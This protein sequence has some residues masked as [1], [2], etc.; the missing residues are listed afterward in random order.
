MNGH[1]PVPTGPSDKAAGPYAEVIVDVPVHAVDRVFHYSVPD[2]L[3]SRVTVGSRVLVPFGG[4]RVE[5]YVVGFAASTTVARVRPLLAVQGDGAYFDADGLRLA[6]WLADRYLALEADALRCLAPPGATARRQGGRTVGPRLLKGY[7]LNVPPEQGRELVQRLAESG[8]RRQAAAVTE[9]LRFADG[10]EPLPAS[11]LSRQTGVSSGSLQSLAKQGILVEQTVRIERRPLGAVSLPTGSKPELTEEQ[12]AALDVLRREWAREQPRPVLLHGVTGSGK[13]E[14]YLRLIEDVLAA[15]K[16]AIVLVPEIALTPQTFSRFAARFGD[17]VALLHSRLSAGERF[18]QWEKVATGAAPVVIGARSAIFAPVQ[19]LGLVIVDEEHETSYK[20]E[21]SPRYH[22]RD[23]AVERARQVGALCVLG[24]ATPA[25][26]SWVKARQGD[27]VLVGMTKRVDDRPMPEVEVVDM[28][29]EMLEGNRSMF[30]RRLQEEL[31]RCLARGRQA[32]LFLNRRGHSQ[33]VLC[34]ECGLV[35]RCDDCDVSC[36]FHEHPAPHLRCHYCDDLQ[37]VPAAC[38]QCHGR[39]L[40]PFGAGTQRVEQAVRQLF[41]GARVQRID[42]DT[43]SRKDEHARLFEKVRR[44]DVDVIVGTQM[45]A[46]GLDFPNVTLVGVVAAD[47]SLHLPDFRAAERTFQLLTQVGGRAGRDVHEGKVLIQTYAPEHYSIVAARRYDVTGFYTQ[48]ARFREGS[49][50]PPFGSLVRIL[51]SSAT[52][53]PGAAGLIADATRRAAGT[54]LV[55]VMGPSP[56]PMH[57]LRGKYRWHILIKG[58][59]DAPRQ[60]AAAAR[61]L[62]G[63]LLTDDGTTVAVDVDPLSLT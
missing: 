46:K 34:R 58:P 40:R 36:T 32:L 19:R 51:V 8:A 23:V 10:A 25:L 45:V 43:T 52:P 22:G 49:G 48:E 33:F 12:R 28:R 2:R 11:Y 44:G 53:H 16:G 59:G 56:A 26:E 62:W 31:S 42:L 20:Q 39:Y 6:R 18:D 37:A 3:L 29:R 27:Y 5:G 60:T 61:E 17:K 7:R 15:G 38:P 30:S 63:P 9:L 47:T 13:T 1:N 55:T 35:I 54:G 4:R 50:Y 57:K 24:S 41:P 21:E 14:V